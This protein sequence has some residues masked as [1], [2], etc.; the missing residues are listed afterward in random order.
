MLEVVAECVSAMEAKATTTTTAKV[1]TATVS[2]LQQRQT[3][4]LKLEP[5][6]ARLQV[7]RS[8]V[9]EPLTA[10]E[11][12]RLVREA[13]RALEQMKVAREM[14]E[15][16]VERRSTELPFTRRFGADRTSTKRRSPGSSAL[17]CTGWTS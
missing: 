17:C 11:R 13:R 2:V 8:V 3:K 7:G 15:K 5:I 10:E 4:V 12:S 6:R 9:S 14:A 1:P 16:K